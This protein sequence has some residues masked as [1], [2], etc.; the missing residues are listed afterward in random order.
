MYFNEIME[1][2]KDAENP[3]RRTFT[4]CMYLCAGECLYFYFLSLLTGL[5]F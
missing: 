2:K 5:A 3:I 4:C 1:G